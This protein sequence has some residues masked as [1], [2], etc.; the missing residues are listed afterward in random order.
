M[1][2]AKHCFAPT[3]DESYARNYVEGTPICYASC[4]SG[5]TGSAQNLANEL[6]VP[7]Y[8]PTRP[9]A[10]NDKNKEWVQDETY[11]FERENIKPEWKMFF[12]K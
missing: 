7:V 8:A 11:Y 6:G 5:T 2:T 9:V 4:W 10:W 3:Q 12:P 1:D